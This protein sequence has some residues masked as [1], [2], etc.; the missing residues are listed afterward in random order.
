MSEAT[1]IAQLLAAVPA[2][3]PALAVPGE[4][5]LSHGG[6]R[7]LSR[8]T[9]AWLNRQGIGRNDRVASLA[10]DQQD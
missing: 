9:G 5:P 10:P 6:L 3:R 1:T 2:E 8:D 4:P 7:Q